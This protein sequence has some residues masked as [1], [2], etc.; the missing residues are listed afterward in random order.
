MCF[1]GLVKTQTNEKNFFPLM[2]EIYSQLLSYQ[3]LVSGNVKVTEKDLF[4]FFSKDL[5]HCKSFNG[6][7]QLLSNKL[8]LVLP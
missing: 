8:Q 6:Q 4:R 7:I 1:L 5:N 3:H 2:Q